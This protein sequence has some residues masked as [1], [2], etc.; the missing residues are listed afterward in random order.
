LAKILASDFACVEWH[1]EP[2]FGGREPPWGPRYR[3]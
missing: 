2:L 1:R 3:D